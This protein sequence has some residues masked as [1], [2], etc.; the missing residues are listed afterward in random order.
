MVLGTLSLK[1]PVYRLAGYFVGGAHRAARGEYAQSSPI[2]ATFTF[3]TGLFSSFASSPPY[4]N[5]SETVFPV[6]TGVGS[7]TERYIGFSGS[8][9]NETAFPS[10]PF[11]SLTSSFSFKS[12]RTTRHTSPARHPP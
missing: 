1:V 11:T 2:D 7:V 10:R 3:G 4:A 5:V 12:N 9:W 6:A 8:L